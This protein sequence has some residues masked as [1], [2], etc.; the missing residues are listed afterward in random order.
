MNRRNDIRF[1][2]LGEIVE[3]RKSRTGSVY[4]V[5]A[6]EE[7]SLPVIPGSLLKFFWDILRSNSESDCTLPCRGVV[8]NIGILSYEGGTMKTDELKERQLAY[9]SSIP[10]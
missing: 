5:S 3:T 2:T 7:R 8:Y 1:A 10:A 4:F 9:I 6:G